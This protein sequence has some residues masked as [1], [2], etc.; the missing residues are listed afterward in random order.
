MYAGMTLVC[1]QGM[2]E[3][4]PRKIG[5]RHRGMIAEQLISQ[6][7]ML[8]IQP[9]FAVYSHMPLLIILRPSAKYKHPPFGV[10][11]KRLESILSG[12]FIDLTNAMTDGDVQVGG[13]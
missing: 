5:M 1:K 10:Q 9:A 8:S 13:V 2:R 11:R 3:A 4:V 7:A 6:F 12:N